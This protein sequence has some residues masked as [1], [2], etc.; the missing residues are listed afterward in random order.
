MPVDKD[1]SF[2]PARPAVFEFVWGLEFLVAI[3]CVGVVVEA[4][5][6]ATN[7]HRGLP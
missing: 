6:P 2:M 4:A 3:L 1:F 7:V 5:R